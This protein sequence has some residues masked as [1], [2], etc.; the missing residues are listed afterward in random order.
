MFRN[1]HQFIP[2]QSPSLLLHR[3]ESYAVGG[4]GFNQT[5]DYW[6]R[7]PAAAQADV[8]DVVWK[9]SLSSSG[10]FVQFATDATSVGLAYTLVPNINSGATLTKWL[11]NQPPPPPLLPLKAP[12]PP[13]L[14]RPSDHIETT[15]CWVCLSR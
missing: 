7:L 13:F 6:N 2:D 3:A 8:R 5:L 12:P 11:V 15:S 9:L 10:M 1:D 4:R 14:G